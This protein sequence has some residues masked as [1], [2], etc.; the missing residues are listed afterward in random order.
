M[1][2]LTRFLKYAF[3]S[4][5]SQKFLGAKW[6]PFLLNSAPSSR[7]RSWALRI[8]SLSPHYFAPNTSN[9]PTT[10]HVEAESNRNVESRQRIFQSIVQPL[11]NKDSVVLDYG[12]GPGYLARIVAPY[13][14]K[15]YAIDISIGALA[16]AK[17]LN[18]ADNIEYSTKLQNEATDLD[19]IYSFAVAYHVTDEVLDQILATCQKRLKAGGRVLFHVKI[20]DPISR[21]EE[22]WKADK[23]LAGQIKFK[24][25]LHYFTRS[26]KSLHA[27]FSR[28]FRD[29][30][31]EPAPAGSDLDGEHIL[32]GAR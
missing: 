12:C 26:E 8:L 6:V 20:D 17:I 31:I 22:Q 30:S 18:N 28:Y 10:E 5:G 4:G 11:L 7:K 15:L 27:I 32:I 16:C 24:Y 1:S 23:S 14:R 21:T 13:V 29:I 9:R 19:L 25:G 2:K 3:S